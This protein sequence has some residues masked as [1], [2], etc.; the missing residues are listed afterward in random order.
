MT[1]LPFK[2]KDECIDFASDLV[3]NLRE[4]RTQIKQL[5]IE[6]KI[7]LEGMEKRL[8]PDNY[9]YNE[10]H[11]PIARLSFISTQRFSPSLLKEENPQIYGQF[12]KPSTYKKWSII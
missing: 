7:I 3:N 2:K 12:V 10:N 5:K 11:K 4:I 1:L 6:E 9:L 8:S